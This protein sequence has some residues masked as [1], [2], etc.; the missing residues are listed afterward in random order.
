VISLKRYLDSNRD[1]LLQTVLESYRAALM[2]MGSAGERACPPV[3]FTLK[4]NLTELQHK[5]PEEATPG[6]VREAHA[7]VETALADWAHQATG[8][9][10][11]RADEF[12]ELLL[13]MASTAESVGERDAHYQEQFHTLSAQ[14]SRIADLHDLKQIRTSLLAS[15]VELKS[16]VQKMARD[17]QEAVAQLRAEVSKCQTRIEEAERMAVVDPLTGLANRRGIERA[18]ESRI[19]QAR[20]FCLMMVDLNGFKTLND[21]HGHLAGDQVLKQFAS[22]LKAVFRATD[23]VGR[24]AGDEFVVVLGALQAEADELAG[25]VQR[26]VFGEYTVECDG[27]RRR[28]NVDAAVGVTQWQPPE[29]LAALLERA[30]KLMYAQ[31]YSREPSSPQHGLVNTR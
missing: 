9:Y 27:V 24:W 31:K 6:Q 21:V 8:Y 28:V 30:D 11:Q 14:L 4:Q 2:A 7:E 25:R 15:A 5:V 29:S 19:S 3:G 10:R 22:E 1:E 16:C 17:G 18:I 13:V 26:W 12:K 23:N 20:C